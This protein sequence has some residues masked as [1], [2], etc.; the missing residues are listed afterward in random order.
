MAVKMDL[1]IAGHGKLHVFH[2]LA[3]VHLHGEE[4]FHPLGAEGRGGK[5]PGKILAVK[6]MRIQP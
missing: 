6:G 4:L 1:R 5:T 3:G 2:H